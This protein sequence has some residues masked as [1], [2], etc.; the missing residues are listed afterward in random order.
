MTSLSK[1]SQCVFRFL[2]LP[3]EIQQ[4]IFLTCLLCQIRDRRCN[5]DRPLAINLLLANHAAFEHLASY[6]YHRAVF[7]FPGVKYA[8]QALEKDPLSQVCIS[9]MKR[10]VVTLEEIPITNALD[11]N[12][13]NTISDF[14]TNQAELIKVLLN[15]LEQKNVAPGLTDIRF[16]FKFIPLQDLEYSMNDP[17]ITHTEQNEKNRRILGDLSDRLHKVP[18]QLC[19]AVSSSYPNLDT[20]MFATVQTCTNGHTDDMVELCPDVELP[21]EIEYILARGIVVLL[22]R[23]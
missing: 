1:S 15:A 10:I 23:K 7:R 18:L 2:D 13:G 16:R 14:Q 6:W 8:I 5:P 11:L 3:S 20:K 21:K 17:W 22:A 9:N 12:V 19:I 4:Q